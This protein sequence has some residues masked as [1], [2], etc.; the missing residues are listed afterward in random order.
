MQTYDRAREK[1]KSMPHPKNLHEYKN[2]VARVEVKLLIINENLNK[3]LKSTEH[4]ALKENDKL[5]L[6]PNKVKFEHILSQMRLV[7]ILSKELKI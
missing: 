3:E 4:Q 7:K 6:K 5:S 2:I 1:L